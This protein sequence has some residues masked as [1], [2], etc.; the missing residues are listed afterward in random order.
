MVGDCLVFSNT[1]N[2]VRLHPAVLNKLNDLAIAD[3]LLFGQNQDLA[4]SVFA[5]I[6]RLPPANTLTCSAGSLRVERYWTLPVDAGE[7]RYRRPEEY[8][9][10]L[11]KKE[12]LGHA[13]GDR[14]RA[15]ASACS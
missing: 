11:E 2:C 5:D 13:V 3:F 15:S 8:A 14:L 12:L 4:T 7:I 9:E 10:H 1:L 6:M